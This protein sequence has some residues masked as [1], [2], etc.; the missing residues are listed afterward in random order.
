[1]LLLGYPYHG[2]LNLLFSSYNI[3]FCCYQVVLYT[4][5]DWLKGNSVQD[6]KLQQLKRKAR[7]LHA[8]AADVNNEIEQKELQ[9]GKRRK[10]E[11]DNWLK[12]V[13]EVV[14][15]LQRLELRGKNLSA[16]KWGG[17]STNQTAQ[18]TEHIGELIKQG[19]FPQGFTFYDHGS[20][21]VALVTTDIKIN[22]NT[23]HDN[24]RKVMSWL[25]EDN[26]N[27]E[28]IS[29]IGIYGP[30]GVGKTMLLKETHNE[31]L[32]LFECSRRIYWVSVSHGITLPM[33]QDK[34]AEAMDLNYLITEKNA[35]RKAASL[36]YELKQRKNVFLFLDDVWEYFPLEEVGIPV[37]EENGC[38][39]ILTSRSLDVCRRMK[40][41][42]VIKVNP[43]SKE[44]AWELFAKVLDRRDEIP[45]EITELAELVAAECAGLPLSLILMAG[46]MRAVNNI[47]EWRNTL[48]EL[49]N[50]T[51]G[52]AV[53]ETDI[54]PV[55]KLSYDRLKD[56]KL[57]QCFLLCALYPKYGEI[58]RD[59]LIVLFRSEGLLDTIQ[60]WQKQFD[61]GHSML[62]KLENV[63]LLERYDSKCVKMHNF[64]RD[65]AI[66]ITN[67]M[68]RFMIAAGAKLRRIPSGRRWTLDLDK[69][70]LM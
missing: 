2:Y 56:P 61:K 30:G 26:N 25:M 52:Q 69:A 35:I 68:P 60:N 12:D 18:L 67:V 29:I 4:I 10:R 11:V 9:P 15:Q 40:C 58:T 43:L 13:D 39:L 1:M 47:Q 34:I 5:M 46:S 23:L 33:L 19:S 63:C 50:S 54:F 28:V 24:K 53:I 21:S 57:R 59:E 44:K 66:R 16:S 64:I 65:M 45:S 17:S 48:E 8:R 37:G 31:L 36:S 38:K 62:N 42:E 32:E 51:E 55:L 27:A 22:D 41:E 20:S 6:H 3:F 49:Q 70:S 7:A 14:D